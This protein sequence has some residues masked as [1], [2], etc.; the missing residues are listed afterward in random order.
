[1]GT[2]T[3]EDLEK[4]EVGSPGGPDDPV[5]PVV[6]RLL[7]LRVSVI[8][9]QALGHGGSLTD[10]IPRLAVLVELGVFHKNVA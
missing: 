8:R 4:V 5:G 6:S 10:N 2:P 9:T 1:M 3:V 7:I